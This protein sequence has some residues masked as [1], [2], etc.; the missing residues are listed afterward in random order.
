MPHTSSSTIALGDYDKLVAALGKAFDGTA[1][2]GST[3]PIVYGEFGVESTIPAEKSGRYTGA[4]PA[5][6]GAVDE[7]TQA[8][9]Y[10]EAFKLALCQPNVIGIYVFHVVD[11]SSLNAWQSGPFYT[12][13]TPKSSL[14][15]IR[16]AADAARAGTLASCPDKAA[17]KVTMTGPTPD[18]MISAEATD[19]IGIGKVEAA[20]N[21][22]VEAVKYTAPYAFIWKPAVEGRYTIEMRATD[23]SGN[24][25]RAS[26]T[27]TAV[28]SATGWTFGPPPVNDLFSAPRRL[29]SWRGLVTGT[30][31]Y[32]AAERGE[33]LRKSV[34]YSWRAPAS[35]KLKLTAAGANV[36]VFT[37]GSVRALRRVAPASRSVTF[38]A[39]RGTKYRIAVDGSQAFR[40]AWKRG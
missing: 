38:E 20:V 39:K 7:A 31:T 28:R 9:Y 16:S 19:D 29:A 34:W 14:G 5:D 24:V 23:G 40:L 6:W 36:S 33:P 3:V 10:T 12:D 4:Q 35:G 25:G 30:A 8:A 18:G 21:G 2:K 11:E 26:T 15:A 32:A 17:P 1:Q 37:G 22:T 13:G 27:I